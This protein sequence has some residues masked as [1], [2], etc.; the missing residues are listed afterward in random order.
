MPCAHIALH[1]YSYEG[2]YAY[3]GEPREHF[4]D[5]MIHLRNWLE[6]R[7]ED[8]IVVVCHWG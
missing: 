8:V 6:E 1:Y 5:R 7:P 2:K 4:R 3:A